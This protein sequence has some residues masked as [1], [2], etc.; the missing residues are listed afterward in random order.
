MIRSMKQNTGLKLAITLAGS[1][2]KLA[3]MLGGNVRQQHVSYWLRTGV[4]VRRAIQIEKA[5][6]GK[7]TREDMCPDIFSD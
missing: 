7:V 4:P 3:T 1:Q 2:A 6:I 5:L